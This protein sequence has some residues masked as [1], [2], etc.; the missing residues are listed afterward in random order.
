MRLLLDEN[1]SPSLPDELVKI[2]VD[3]VPLRDRG[4]LQATDYQVWR[5]AQDE[6]RAIVTINRKHFLP[7]AA[8]AEH[9]H[10]VVAIPSGGR[11]SEQFTYITTAVDWATAANPLRRSFVN[12]LVNV[13]EEGKVEGRILHVMPAAA[14]PMRSA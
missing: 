11:P 6:Q 13:Y 8:N 4:M 14:T 5:F 3:A 1:I 12:L 7:F 9:H 10:G 2:G